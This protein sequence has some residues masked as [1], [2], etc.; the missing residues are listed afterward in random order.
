MK[1]KKSL[2]VLS[3]SETRQ[4]QIF[5]IHRIEPLIFATKQYVVLLVL[6]LI[7][8]DKTTPRQSSQ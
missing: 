4:I 1:R 8:R 5:T 2:T 6:N 3:V 7:P